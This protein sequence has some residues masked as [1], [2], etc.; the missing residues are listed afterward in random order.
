MSIIKC[1]EC[2]A[3]I[4]DKALFCP[5]CGFSNSTTKIST[6]NKKYRKLP[7]GFGTIKVL[8]GK[9]RKPYAVYPSANE[10]DMN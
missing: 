3:D 7:N 6:T 9:R 8:S 4:S 2:H 5:H 1:A 10:K